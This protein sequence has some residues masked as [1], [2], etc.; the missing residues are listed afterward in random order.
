MICSRLRLLPTEGARVLNAYCL[1][2]QASLLG[3]TTRLRGGEQK[4]SGLHIADAS[5]V[6]QNLVRSSLLR[7]PWAPANPIPVAVY[8][9]WVGARGKRRGFSPGAAARPLSGPEQGR[10]FEKIQTQ[11]Y[12]LV[13]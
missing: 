5:V 8:W 7:A 1:Y 3:L 4:T 10:I 13:M 2:E 12:N 11:Y 9:W 6:P